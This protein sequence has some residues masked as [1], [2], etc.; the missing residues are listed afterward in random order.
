MEAFERVQAAR[1][2][3]RP[4]GTDFINHIFDD[5]IEMHGDR[6]FG[7]D[8]AIVAGIARLNGMPVTVITGI[9]APPIP[10]DTGRP[11]VR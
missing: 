9:L 11:F 2:K 7:D 5:F 3:G 1:S 8:K 10:R 6:R 4:T